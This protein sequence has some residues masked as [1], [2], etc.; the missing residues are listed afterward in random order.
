M[1]RVEPEALRLFCPCFTD[2]F[3]GGETLE[4]LQSASEVISSDEGVEVASE[5]VVAVVMEAFDRR[6][7]D[8]AVHAFDLGVGPWLPWFSE[9]VIDAVL[10]ACEFETV[11]P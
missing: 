11:R 8:G 10:G 1:G 2:G 3:V 9:T 5:L 7:L 6:L 4:G